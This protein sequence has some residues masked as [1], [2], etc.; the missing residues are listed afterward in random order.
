MLKSK[1]R[2]KEARRRDLV[3]NTNKQILN[4]VGLACLFEASSQALTF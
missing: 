2:L 4:L 1:T 3:Q